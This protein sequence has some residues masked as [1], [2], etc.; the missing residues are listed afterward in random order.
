MPENPDAIVLAIVL[1]ARLLVPLTIPKYPIPA[2]IG[3]LVIDGVDKSLLQSLTHLP[4][5]GYQGYDKALDIYYLSIQYLSTLRNWIDLYAV[6]LGPA[7]YCFRLVGVLL[8]ELLQVRA[9][10]LLFPNTFEYFFLFYEGVRLRWNPRRMGPAVVIGAAFAIWVLIKIPQEYW[11]H[12]AQLDATDAIKERLFRVSAETPWSAILAGNVPLA[13]LLLLLAACLLAAAG[14]YIT[15]NLPPADW[16]FSFAA[17][18]H[19][20][21]VTPAEAVAAQRRSAARY[22]DT[23]LLEKVALIALTT[24]IFSEVLPGA[25]ATPVQT[26]TGVAIVILAN[27]FITEWLVRRGVWWGSALIG[28]LTTAAVNIGIVAVFLVVLPLAGGSFDLPATGFSLFLLTLLVTLYDRFRPYYL[29]R[30]EQSG[31]TSQSAEAISTSATLG[32]GMR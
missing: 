20:R 11:I 3:A 16:R 15:H 31:I 32:E 21:D 24:V 7:L 14:S 8:F 10:L 19:G 13:V 12:V 30:R 1:G 29:V 2:G 4:L 6:D 22:F 18:A 28:F 26:A 25:R 27:T 5:D 9:L 17:D 23:E